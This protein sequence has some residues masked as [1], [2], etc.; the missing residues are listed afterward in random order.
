MLHYVKPALPGSRQAEAVGPRCKGEATVLKVND[1]LSNSLSLVVIGNERSVRRRRRNLAMT[2]VAT[3]N[4][5][6]RKY[7]LFP[8]I[9]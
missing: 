8:K 2:A 3:K 4:P 7:F 5:L 6:S 1:F 9:Y